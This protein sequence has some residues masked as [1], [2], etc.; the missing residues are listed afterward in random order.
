VFLR[1]IDDIGPV[2][3]GQTL[4]EESLRKPKLTSSGKLLDRLH[5]GM[6]AAVY[7]TGLYEGISRESQEPPSDII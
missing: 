4:T 5:L 6:P 7:A 1:F 2:R 3:N